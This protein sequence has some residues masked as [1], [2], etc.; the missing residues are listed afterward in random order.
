M[1]KPTALSFLVILILLSFLFI[2]GETAVKEVAQYVPAS[3]T[4]TAAVS[5][6][7]LVTVSNTKQL[8]SSGAFSV[9]FW[10]KGRPTANADLFA[11]DTSGTADIALVY[12]PGLNAFGYENE[13]QT[14]DVVTGWNY[15]LDNNWHHIVLVEP[16]T[17]DVDGASFYVDGVHHSAANITTTQNVPTSN[18][19]IGGRSNGE[20]L[21]PGEIDDFRLYDSVLS[22]VEVQELYTTRGAIP[23]QPPSPEVVEPEDANDTTVPPLLPQ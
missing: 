5:D 9:S 13:L 1:E 14:V 20:L 10:M 17:G 19:Y 16:Y 11:Q 4:Q 15:T 22:S 18:L 12:L 2:L 3:Q 7:D 21:Y 23:V 8:P 6:F